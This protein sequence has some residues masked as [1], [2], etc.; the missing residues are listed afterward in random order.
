MRT[1]SG[2]T[3]LS[4]RYNTVQCLFPSEDVKARISDHIRLILQYCWDKTIARSGDMYEDN[5]GISNFVTK[6]FGITNTLKKNSIRISTLIISYNC[7]EVF[8]ET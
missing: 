8:A 4:A 1:Q 6:C 3:N 5:S 2:L 7:T